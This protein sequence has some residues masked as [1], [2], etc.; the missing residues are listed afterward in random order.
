MKGVCSVHNNFISFI[1]LNETYL[2]GILNAIL[3]VCVHSYL[4]ALPQVRPPLNPPIDR[5]VS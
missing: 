1:S 2:K 4:A 5:T 3:P